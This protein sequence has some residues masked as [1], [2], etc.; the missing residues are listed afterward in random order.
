M[1]RKAFPGP[2]GLKMRATPSPAESHLMRDWPARAGV[3]YHPATMAVKRR[4]RKK[5]CVCPAKCSR[6]GPERALSPVECEGIPED[7][8]AGHEKA[9]R[10]FVAC[11]Y[12]GLFSAATPRWRLPLGWVK[13]TRWQPANL[14]RLELPPP[15]TPPGGR[16]MGGRR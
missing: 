9:G 14:P 8:R 12:C 16:R 5:P 13:D 1:P 2:P 10:G 4:L 7:I 6:G 3:G 15:K 11:T